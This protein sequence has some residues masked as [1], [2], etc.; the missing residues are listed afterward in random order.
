MKTKTRNH[1]NHKLHDALELLNEAAQEKRTELYDLIGDK[2]SHFKEVL[3][4]TA[5]NGKKAANR[6]GKE[7]FKALQGREEQ[8]VHKAK[9]IDKQVHQNP[10][11]Y[12]GIVAVSSVL[13][14]YMMNHKR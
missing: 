12:V 5:K 13:L 14:G 3:S 4:D 6:T 7:L 9:E 8:F 2:Y 11:L 1:E 10:W